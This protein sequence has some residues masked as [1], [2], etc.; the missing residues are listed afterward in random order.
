MKRPWPISAAHLP[1][2]P[3]REASD[4]DDPVLQI[5]L[6]RA[7]AGSRP[8]KREDGHTVCLAI[9]G[10]AMRGSVSAGMCVA[11][12]AAGLMS[13]FDRVYGC[14]AGA[15][16]GSFSA[17]GQAWLGAT[18]YEESANRRF[19][20]ARR[21]VRGKPVVDLELVFDELLALKRPFC[22]AG[23]AAGPDFRAV[24][25]SPR[26]QEVRVLS[27]LREPGEIL[28]AVRASCSVPMLYGNA[29][30]FRGEPLVD[31]GFLESVPY[32]SALREGATHVLVLRSSPASYRLPPYR[33]LTELAIRLAGTELVSMLR[34]RPERYNRDADELEELASHPPGR[35]PVTQVVVPP[36][37]RLID[38]L[39]MDVRKIRQGLRFGA[40][41]IAARVLARDPEAALA[42]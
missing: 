32:R 30:S 25:V 34:D 14:S 5:V 18:T 19:I 28:D 42:A 9:E 29:R 31:G 35:R 7:A 26:E 2:G 15:V 3:L 41:A 33:K 11:L 38:T 8:G 6:E 4:A 20:D 13:A 24:A 23:L 16:N 21:L 39:E 27:D 40:A 36:G 22:R 1:Q 10:G 37:H 17:S 12:E